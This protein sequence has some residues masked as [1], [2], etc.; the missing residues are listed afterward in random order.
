MSNPELYA[1]PFSEIDL[2]DIGSVGGKNAS[3]GEMIQNLK[4]A[5]IEIPAGF[6][7][8]AKA[9]WDHLDQNNI[10]KELE[11]LLKQL[12]L[13][14]FSNLASISKEARKLILRGTM[15]NELQEAVRKA[16]HQ[17]CSQTTENV[18]VAV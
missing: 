12:D 11:T 4:P 6:A 16:Y 14:Q 2:K 1:V 10:R 18:S 15:P 3:L 17:L 7:V 9:Y 13:D 8:T 5:G